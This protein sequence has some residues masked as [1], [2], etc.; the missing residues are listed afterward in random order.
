MLRALAFPWLCIIATSTTAQCPESQNDEIVLYLMQQI[1]EPAAE[2]GI[3]VYITVQGNDPSEKLLADVRNMGVNAEKG[4][5]YT[6]EARLL[7][8]YEVLELFDSC[9]RK[10]RYA[11]QCKSMCGSGGT[12]TMVRT[13]DGWESVGERGW[14]N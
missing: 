3:K 11:F 7:F 8:T 12:T 5:E 1:A 9:D 4:S 6:P 10:I 13:E 2:F 14:V